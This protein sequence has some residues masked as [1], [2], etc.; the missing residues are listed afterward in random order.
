[1]GHISNAQKSCLRQ[2]VSG[3]LSKRMPLVSVIHGVWVGAIAL[4]A[5]LALVLVA[6]KTWRHYPI[7]AAYA[8]FSL[9]E[10]GIGYALFG[11]GVLYFYTF[12][13]CEAIGIVL[14]L[15]V[16]REIFTVLFT[17]HPALRKLA[18]VIFRVAVVALIAL[19]GAAIYTQSWNARGIANSILLAAEAA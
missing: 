8:F 18:T 2:A 6:K 9:L 12:W 14:G 5:L 7:F 19:A 13:I 15:M 4:Q 1:S 10:A 3:M 11:R 17:P 16:V